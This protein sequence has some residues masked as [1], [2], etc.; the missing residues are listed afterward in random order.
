MRGP[1]VQVNGSLAHFLAC[2]MPPKTCANSS[3]SCTLLQ[4]C[5]GFRGLPW[6]NNPLIRYG[7]VEVRFELAPGFFEQGSSP[8]TSC[9]G[10]K[11][12]AD[13]NHGFSRIYYV[14]YNQDVLVF[15]ISIRFLNNSYFVSFVDPGVVFYSRRR[16]NPLPIACLR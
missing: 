8:N 14:I 4:F 3:A 12:I 2:S 11:L 6:K 15:E 9:L 13:E 7:G 16:K 5:L 1:T 10:R